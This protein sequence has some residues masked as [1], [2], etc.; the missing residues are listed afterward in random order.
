MT[1]S[2]DEKLFSSPAANSL[3]VEARVAALLK[4]NKWEAERGVYYPDPE[5]GK[6]RELDV[7]GMQVLDKPRASKG[8]GCPIINLSVFCEC[9]TLSGSNIIFSPSMLPKW[10]TNVSIVHWLGTEAQLRRMVLRIADEIETKDND[11]IRRI[12]NY[13]IERAYPRDERSLRHHAKVSPP[14]VDVFSTTFRETKGGELEK[15]KFGDTNRINPVWSAIRSILAAVEAARKRAKRTSLD[16]VHGSTIK[17]NGMDAFCENTTFFLDAELMRYS[18]FHPFI[19]LGARL[20]C[21]NGDQ[22][23]EVQSAR[24]FLKSLNE[25]NVYVDIVTEHSVDHYIRNMVAHYEQVSR[26]SNAETWN[27]L[28]QLQ[29]QPG[30]AKDDFRKVIGT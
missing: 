21:L 3:K 26:K 16:W 22:L 6:L 24:L 7:Y 4:E 1:G 30:Q 20:W 5:T 25:K 15:E 23:N 14:P 10:V 19:V 17:F 9:K 27:L 11:R 28:K 8:T 13:V 29:W 2:I 12:Y 18:F